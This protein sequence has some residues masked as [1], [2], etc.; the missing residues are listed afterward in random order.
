MTVI[1]GVRARPGGRRALRFEA[2]GYR[3]DPRP[4]VRFFNRVFSAWP[5]FTAGVLLAASIA[6]ALALDPSAVDE[7]LRTAVIA[8][9][10]A[11]LLYLVAGLLYHQ[12]GEIVGELLGSLLVGLLLGL[13]AVWAA[14]WLFLLPFP[15]LRRRA[16]AWWKGRWP[17]EERR[18]KWR[19]RAAYQR[20]PFAELASGS[21]TYDGQGDVVATVRFKDGSEVVYTARGESGEK[22]DREFRRALGNRLGAGRRTP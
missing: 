14:V 6:A 2:T 20:V 16:S 7:R 13:L 5:M 15:R 4:A 18:P 19:S 10:V 12:G 3:A 9:L 11:A 22:L 21:I 8:V 17:D 1:E